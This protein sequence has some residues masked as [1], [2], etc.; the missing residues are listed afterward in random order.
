MNAPEQHPPAGRP[1]ERKGGDRRQ[2]SVSRRALCIGIDRYPQRPLS[3]AANDSRR[4]SVALRNLGFD[5]RLLLDD[6]ATLA[7]IGTAIADALASAPDDSQWVLQFSGHG[8]QLPG[9][10]S[11]ATGSAPWSQAWLPIDHRESGALLARDLHDWLLPH[12]VRLKI[13]VFA[14]CAHPGSQ[15]R[16]RP[17]SR[18]PPA[19][20]GSRFMAADP[21]TLAAQQRRPP[22]ASPLHGLRAGPGVVPGWVYLAAC[23]EDE[24]ALEFGDGGAFSTAAQR[25]L[26]RAFSEC[27]PPARFLDAVR[28]SIRCAGVQT[29]Q[30]LP[31]S[32][33]RGQQPLLG[34]DLTRPAQSANAI[35]GLSLRELIRAVD[36]LSGEPRALGHGDA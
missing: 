31:C 34:A 5:T 20:A 29:P 12:S 2:P 8:S 15:T 24:H 17:A 22:V 6:D 30:L 36:A 3:G 13:T 1:V 9:P 7:G 11:S 10:A 32:G 27:W 14:D 4:W 16:F 25:H 19:H 21:A 35:D 26:P 33:R 23:R 28:T 18:L